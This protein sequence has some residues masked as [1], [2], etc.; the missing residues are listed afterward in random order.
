MLSLALLAFALF[1]VIGEYCNLS[2][3]GSSY[4][5]IVQSLEITSA[6]MLSLAFYMDECDVIF[7]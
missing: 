4:I 3:V 7:L 1:Y 5:L 2:S 6:N